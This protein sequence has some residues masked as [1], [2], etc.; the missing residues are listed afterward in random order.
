MNARKK[1]HRQG[2]AAQQRHDAM[3]TVKE[4]CAQPKLEGGH[5][6]NAKTTSADQVPHGPRSRISSTQEVDHYIGVRY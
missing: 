4:I 5:R 3:L 6:S 1:V 2:L